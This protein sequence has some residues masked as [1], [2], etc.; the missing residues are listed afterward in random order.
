MQTSK[1]EAIKQTKERI[2]DSPCLETPQ[3]LAS[4]QNFNYH[5]LGNFFA[6][7]LD[8]CLYVEF[9]FLIEW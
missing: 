5:P 8:V 9:Q 4:R 2:L 6:S 7:A 3:I 1:A